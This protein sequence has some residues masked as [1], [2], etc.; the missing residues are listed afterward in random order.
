MNIV[1]VGNVRVGGGAL[2]LIAGPCVIE[3]EEKALAAASRLSAVCT[4]IGCPLIYKSSF[5]KA[6][7]SSIRSFRGPGRKEGLRI[8]AKVK[9]DLGLPVLSDVHSVDD[10]KAAAEVL[11]VLQ[12]PAFL[13]RQT[14]LLSAA[15]KAGRPVNVKKG[16]FLAPWDLHHVVEKLESAGARGILLTERGTAFG[17]N[18]LVADMRSLVILRRCGW[19]VVFD[20]SHSVQLPGGQGGASGG[21]RT[22]IPH[23]AR[24]AAAV[25][26]DALF[27]E[28]HEVPDSAPCDGPNMMSLDDLPDLLQSVKAIHE[29]VPKG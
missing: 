23:L 16:Q 1:D 8:L 7:R 14:D 21:D 3:S 13:S 12:I 19:P 18:N 9:S 17:Y 4:E 6:N 28:C 27:V 24:A 25:G 15:A 11:D 10:V 20:V 26:I 5:D 22:F 2:S 29:R